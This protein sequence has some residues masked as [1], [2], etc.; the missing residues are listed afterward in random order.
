MWESARCMAYGFVSAAVVL[1]GWW[2]H[3]VRQERFSLVVAGW[4]ELASTS[5]WLTA[6]A[7]PCADKELPWTYQGPEP[8]GLRVRLNE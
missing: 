6:T 1:L 3:V 4:Q 5:V 8:L 2:L 7:L